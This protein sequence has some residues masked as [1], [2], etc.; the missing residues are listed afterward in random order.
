MLL[1]RYF[2]NFFHTAPRIPSRLVR[3]G[4]IY[5]DSARNALAELEPKT[6]KLLNERFARQFDPMMKRQ[7]EIIVEK[8]QAFIDCCEAYENETVD[9]PTEE[10]DVK[11]EAKAK[12]KSKKRK[13]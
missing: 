6:A 11:A 12:A 2:D 10:D 4:I 3:Y 1:D 8:L 9:G 5:G 7:A 13:A